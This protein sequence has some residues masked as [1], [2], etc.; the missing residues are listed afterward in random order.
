MLRNE[1]TTT[2]RP[3]GS[4]V[5]RLPGVEERMRE[6]NPVG[7]SRYTTGRS[8]GRA[9]ALVPRMVKLAWIPS[10]AD[11]L[12]LLAVF[13]DEPIRNRVML[14]L[15]YDRCRAGKRR[16]RMDRHLERRPKTVRVDKDRRRDPRD[17]LHKYVS[18][19]SGAGH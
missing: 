17:F 11:W 16:P 1:R 10:E 12:R 15:A 6:S 2:R 18:R 4:T 5:L 9:S 13:A 3:S 8:G 14:A 7:R 19:I